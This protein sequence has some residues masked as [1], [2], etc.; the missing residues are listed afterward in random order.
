MI[1][2]TAIVLFACWACFAFAEGATRKDVQK[3]AAPNTT[4]QVL[5]RQ[6]FTEKVAQ[7]LATTFP[8]AKFSVAGE[9]TITRIEADGNNT[10]ISLDNLYR[11]YKIAPG[12]FVA[13]LRDFAAAISR[14]APLQLLR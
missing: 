7:E 10:E 11:D 8:D 12:E 4:T 2:L 9:L 14:T 1:R 13:L 6:A 3:G 5:S